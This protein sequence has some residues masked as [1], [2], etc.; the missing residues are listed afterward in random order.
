ML[1]PVINLMERYNIPRL[2]AITIVFLVI[3]GGAT[4]IIDLLIPVIGDELN[5]LQITSQN[6]LKN[7]IELLIK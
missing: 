5:N 2:L 6:I 3:I 4:L 7:L 1:N